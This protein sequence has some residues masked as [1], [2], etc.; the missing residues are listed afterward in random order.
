MDRCLGISG[1]KSGRDALT[2]INQN[3][4]SRSGTPK[5][6]ITKKRKAEKGGENAGPKKKTK[7][8]EDVGDAGDAG[9][10][11]AKEQ[12]RRVEAEAEDE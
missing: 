1:R 2:K 7:M 5:P 9:D 11:G 6:G 3:G 4:D 12:G 8:D 10:T